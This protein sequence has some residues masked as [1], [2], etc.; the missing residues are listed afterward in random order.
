[1]LALLVL[2]WAGVIQAADTELP[3]RVQGSLNTR[4]V[5]HETLSVYVT[6]LETSETILEWNGNKS[7]NPASTIKLLTTLVA[8]DVLG[9]AYHWRTDVYALGDIDN[10][11]LDGDLAIKGYGD[12]FLVT[13]RVWQLLR[14]IRHAG[15]DEISGDLLLDDSWFSVDDYDPAAF[16]R[17]P[18]QMCIRDMLIKLSL[19]LQ[20]VRYSINKYI[21]FLLFHLSLLLSRLLW[22]RLYTIH[23]LLM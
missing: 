18:L 1:M 11:R 2:I 7:R 14:D 8:L 9:P 13:E 3:L 19:L 22:H 10:G 20:F 17:R 6:D 12:P 15:V 23:L 16:D 4:N 21:L 5:P